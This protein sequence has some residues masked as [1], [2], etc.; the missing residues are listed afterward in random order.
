MNAQIARL[1]AAP[2]SK[3][4]LANRTHPMLKLALRTVASALLIIAYAAAFFRFRQGYYR[5]EE[6]WI[7]SFFLV[8][9]TIFFVRDWIR[10]RKSTKK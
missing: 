7:G 5:M 1:T 8:V 4:P 2:S 6:A 3:Y 9:L 10:E